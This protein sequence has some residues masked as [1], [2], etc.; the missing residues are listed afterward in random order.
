MRGFYAL[1]WCSGTGGRQPFA[2]LVSMAIH[3]L[4][5]GGISVLDREAKVLYMAPSGVQKERMQVHL[6]SP[7]HALR[8]S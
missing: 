7:S 2:L 5:V 6:L 3:S 1:G 4:F 8:Y